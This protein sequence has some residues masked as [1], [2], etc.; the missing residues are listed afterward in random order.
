MARQAR[1]GHAHIH[2]RILEHHLGMVA[3]VAVAFERRS[4]FYY[5]GLPLAPDLMILMGD[6][7]DIFGRSEIDSPPRCAAATFL[8]ISCLCS[9]V[10]ALF[11]AGADENNCEP[12][13]C[14]SH[15]NWMLL[16]RVLPRSLV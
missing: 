7:I 9:R 2:L 6:V 14:V 16:L 11:M 3:L 1:G 8:C 12:R 15:R 13:N 4:H 5:I 10:L